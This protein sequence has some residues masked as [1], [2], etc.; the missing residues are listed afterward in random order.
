MLLLLEPRGETHIRCCRV[1]SGPQIVV[2][3]RAICG[4]DD[5]PL[6]CGL[7]FQWSE[8]GDEFFD[9][10][11]I[12]KLTPNV[13]SGL[14]SVVPAYHLR[15]R[16]HRRS[17][18]KLQ[19]HLPPVHQQLHLHSLVLVGLAL[20]RALALARCLRAGCAAA[21]VPSALAPSALVRPMSLRSLVQLESWMC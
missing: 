2:L 17:L 21:L 8:A 19:A 14:E 4:F 13:P 10:P 18:W 11:A 3:K 7:L 20:V 1:T 16:L 12:L 9:G 6:G 15:H 5:G